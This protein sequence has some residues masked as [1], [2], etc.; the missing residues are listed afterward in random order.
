M[1]LQIYLLHCLK[2]NAAINFTVETHFKL[3]PLSFVLV[4]VLVVNKN[5]AA[6]LFTLFSIPTSAT[7]CHPPLPPVSTHQPPNLSNIQAESRAPWELWLEQGLGRQAGRHPFFLS[8]AAAFSWYNRSKNLKHAKSLWL[9][10]VFGSIG[11]RGCGLISERLI[12]DII[13]RGKVFQSN[14]ASLCLEQMLLRA[15]IICNNMIN[16]QPGLGYTGKHSAL[17]WMQSYIYGNIIVS[18]RPHFPCLHDVVQRA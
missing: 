10:V 18:H 3:F 17:R 7:A 5:C 4:R 14:A 1:H 16:G 11:G 9:L 12:S 15:H 2:S 8:T 13:I 6:F